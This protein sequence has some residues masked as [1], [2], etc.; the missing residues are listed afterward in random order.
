MLCAALLVKLT[1]RGPVIFRQ[2]RIGL[3]EVPF[4]LYK[5]RSM[6]VRTEEGSMYTE[7]K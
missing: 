2:E 5:F 3:R 1:S 7:K 6:K 4:T